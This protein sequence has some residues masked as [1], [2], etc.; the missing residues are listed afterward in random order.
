MASIAERISRGFTKCPFMHS[1]K[2]EAG[3]AVAE[4]TAK[5]ALHGV[6]SGLAPLDPSIANAFVLAHGS[7]GAFPFAQEVERDACPLPHRGGLHRGLRAA[8][9]K[10]STEAQQFD[11][12]MPEDGIQT[13]LNVPF[14]SIGLSGYWVRAPET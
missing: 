1:M 9:V 6:P 5:L 14:A 2:E 11:T 3:E 10:S 8:L 12:D 13:V 4:R 7:D